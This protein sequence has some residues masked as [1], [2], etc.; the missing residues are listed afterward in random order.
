MSSF[1]LYNF[2]EIKNNLRREIVFGG[3][4]QWS[5]TTYGQAVSVSYQLT[6]GTFRVYSPCTPPPILYHKITQTKMPHYWGIFG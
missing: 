5:R 2:F 1:F 4:E 3:G 6:L